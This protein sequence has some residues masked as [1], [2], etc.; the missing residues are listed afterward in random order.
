MESSANRIACISNSNRYLIACLL[1]TGNVEVFSAAH[2]KI[3]RPRF[4]PKKASTI[5][6]KTEGFAIDWIK[7]ATHLAFG[8]NSGQITIT[9]M[10]SNGK[11]ILSSNSKFKAHLSSVED[12]HW[13]PDCDDVIL[14]IF[15]IG[16]M[17]YFE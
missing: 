16:F 11:T 6:G 7:S 3:M 8:D 12:I 13:S 5:I 17:Y 2:R 4:K 9:D 1:D 14:S 15:T 10:E